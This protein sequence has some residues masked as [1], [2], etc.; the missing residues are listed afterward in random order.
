[1]TVFQ[2]DDLTTKTTVDVD[3]TVMLP[4]L[5]EVKIGGMTLAAGHRP[6]SAAL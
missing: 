5:G 3:G 6:D 1:M 2:E 4:L